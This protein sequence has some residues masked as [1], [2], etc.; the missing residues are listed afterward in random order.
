[1]P[2]PPAPPRSPRLY[3]LD[4]LRIGPLHA[5]SGTACGWEAWLDHIADLGF[6]EVLTAPLGQPG[7]NG[8][9]FLAADPDRLNPALDAGHQTALID[10]LAAL[11]QAAQARGLALWLDLAPD[12]AAA[13]GALVT[14]HPDAF[15]TVGSNDPLDPRQ[16]PSVP[17]AAYARLQHGRLAPDL[18]EAWAAR[19]TRWCT[20][21]V[22]GF[23]CDAPQRLHP[24]DW[25]VLKAAAQQAAPDTRLVAWTPGLPAN[26]LPAL[27]KA[28]FDGVFSSLPWWDYRSPWLADEVTRLRAVAPVIAVPA[29]LDTDQPAP[30]TD[31]A[32][33]ALWTAAL[34][35]DGW[36]VPMGFD[37]SRPHAPAHPASRR[38]AEALRAANQWLDSQHAPV[39][40]LRQLSQPEAG[41]TVLWRGNPGDDVVQ[42]ES[43]VPPAWLLTL[44]TVAQAPPQPDW[45]GI[46]PR[47]PDLR[48]VPG[49]GPTGSEPTVGD[50]ATSAWLLQALVASPPMLAGGRRRTEAAAR[51]ALT[52]ALAAPRLV[53]TDLT[54]VVNGGIHALKRTPGEPVQV[55]ATIFTDGHEQLSAQLLWR[56]IDTA[57]WTTVP[58][59]LLGNDRWQAT[60]TPQ[61]LGQYQYTVE[62]WCNPHATNSHSLSRKFA[63][64]RDVRLDIHEACLLLDAAAD[65]AA[66]DDAAP[67]RTTRETAAASDVATAVALLCAVATDTLTARAGLRPFLL[68]HDPPAALLVERPAARFASWYE[69]F[70]RSQ[71]GD[72]ARHGTFADVAARLPA[73]RAMGFDVLYFPPIHPI[74]RTHRKGR[75][76]SLHAGPDEPGSP[77]AI[78]AEDGGHDAIHRELGTLEDFLALVAQA[79]RHEL[80]IALDF[81][82]QCSPDHPWLRAHPEWFSYRADGSMRHAE[83]PPK[84]YEDIVNV[85]FY[86][87]VPA[88]ATPGTQSPSAA[89]WRALRDVVLFWAGHGVRIFRVDNPHTKPLPFWQWMIAE[90][91]MRHPDVIFLSEAFTR[92]AM[93]YRLAQVG[94]TQS[95]TYFTWREHKQ[96]LIAYL[97]TLSTPPVVDFFRPHFFV[98]TPDINPRFLHHAGR[99]GFLIRAALAATTAGLWGMYSG[100]ELCEAR[101]VPG[102]EEYLDSE[103]YEIRAWDWQ[104]PGHIIDEI[105]QLNRLRR[106]HP[107]LQTQRGIVF[108]DCNDDQVLCYSRATP[109]GDDVVLVVVS[110]DPHHTHYPT[111]DLPLA[112]LHPVPA[113]ATHPTLPDDLAVRA[114]DLLD[115]QQQHWQ[116]RQRT[117]TLTPERP[118]ALWQLWAA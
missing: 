21:G 44:N 29:P 64:G 110:L 55:S 117:V 92:P 39:G 72:P 109:E 24:D 99:P 65:Q 59:T 13:T 57:T 20:A 53:I 26:A 56:A 40:S 94:F 2:Q 30:D 90:V 63:A 42:A 111:V 118:Y 76:N 7:A 49:P 69:L 16:A 41:T 87:P 101:A 88:D 32:L 27:A 11:A 31:P 45:P 97:Q 60:F 33:R 71:S 115:D 113:G 108:H 82:I 116:G 93:M 37:L 28:G 103:K 78:G 6:L 8:D 15:S 12:R 5:A 9:P 4:P 81:A 50:D 58:M 84:Q 62:A 102:K 10:A 14:Q 67:L 107:A 34:T 38:M 75:N 80:E 19:I 89:L 36:L 52:T 74:G 25:A 22:R 46:L 18:L 85:A 100:F 17:Q 79:R 23:R 1:M 106:A 43:P 54:P 61:R 96:E 47:L 105:T 70:P 77:Y 98:N 95:Y 112:R 104:Q 68:R 48:H 73:I 86:A 91:Q 3:Y 83:N 35:G 66:P 51:K 114:H